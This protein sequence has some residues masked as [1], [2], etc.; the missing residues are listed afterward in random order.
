VLLSSA[1]TAPTVEHAA[2]RLGVDG[3]VSSAVDLYPDGDR[4]VYSA[5]VG[6]PRALAGRKPRYFSRPGAVVHNSAANKVN[7]LRVYHPEVFA[8]DAVSVGITDNNY[9]EDRTWTHHFTHVIG[10]NSRH[11]FSPFVV[12]DSPCASIQMIDAAPA[13]GAVAGNAAIPARKFA[14]H[15]TLRPQ[16]FDRGAL[17]ARFDAEELSRV[18]ALSEQ[19]RAARE[20]AGAAVDVSLRAG[21]AGIHAALSN[22]VERY[23]R[24]SSEQKANI[25]KELTRLSRSARKL[26]AKLAQ[27]GRESVGIQHELECIHNAAARFLVSRGR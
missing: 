21:L 17:A 26:S 18:E 11:P 25:R 8:P 4:E 27:G 5:P 14:W 20:R 12:A 1:S 22:A 7:F 15:G 2:R 16:S 24:A 13:S 9:G 6:L 19:L 10:L 3:F 23:N